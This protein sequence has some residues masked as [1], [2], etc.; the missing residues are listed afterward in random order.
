MITTSSTK[1]ASSGALKIFF[2]SE[3]PLMSQFFKY[4]TV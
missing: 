2:F 1:I 3:V 4:A